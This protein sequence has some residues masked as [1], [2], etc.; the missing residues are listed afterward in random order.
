MKLLLAILMIHT[1]SYAQ[2]FENVA[3]DELVD[4]EKKIIDSIVENEL[5]DRKNLP[6]EVVIVQLSDILKSPT[7]TVHISKGAKL[8]NLLTGDQE[9]L[10]KDIYAIAYTRPDSSGYFYLKN[11]TGAPKYKTLLKNLTDIS[12]VTQMY[13]P[14][15][16]YRPISETDRPKEMNDTE[17]NFTT[18]FNLHLG[19]TNPGFTKDLVNDSHIG[20]LLGYEAQIYDN[21]SLPFS[22][23]A[24][25]LYET[26]SANIGEGSENY[27][28][29]AL[30]LGAL[31][32]FS[33]IDFFGLAFITSLGARTSAFSK[34]NE[35]RSE[36]TLSYNLS[37]NEIFGA[38]QHV[39]TINDINATLGISFKRQWIKASSNE[40]RTDLSNDNS[41]DDSISVTIGHLARWP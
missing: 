39:I 31:V 7:Q 19:A 20:R 2:D 24:T 30:S 16:Y 36:E 8:I 40:F 5:K 41:F 9:L 28:S 26:I 32:K 18:E 3:I 12:Q 22:I 11:N 35:Q 15:V 14:P 37:K 17:L 23:G 25:L 21:F 13:E 27:N 6:K 38:V 34:I 33:P 10:T 29:N 4:R 1:C